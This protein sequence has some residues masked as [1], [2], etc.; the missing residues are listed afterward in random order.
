M[1]REAIDDIPPLKTDL[2][3]SRGEAPGNGYEPEASRNSSTEKGS[4]N[5]TS[6]VAALRELRR[7][8]KS[9][10]GVR[11]TGA[12]LAYSLQTQIPFD[13]IAVYTRTVAAIRALYMNGSCEC[14]FSTQAFPLGQG[15]SG[16]VVENARCIVNGNPTV[17]PNFVVSAGLFTPESSALAVPLF[18]GIG[19]VFGAVA[20]YSRNAAAFSKDHRRVLDET[21]SE[22]AMAL[23]SAMR[24]EETAAEG[25]VCFDAAA[26]P[27]LEGARAS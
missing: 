1:A 16:W 10:C 24:A 22:F 21:M 6:A 23:E 2:Y 26:S 9:A 4:D 18:S 17:E 20:L 11:E 15:L 19:R 25:R 27:V 5:S 14:A 8:L 12:V 3:I 13:C 7:G